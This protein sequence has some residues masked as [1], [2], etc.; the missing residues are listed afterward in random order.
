MNSFMY[1]CLYLCCWIYFGILD[2]VNFHMPNKCSTKCF[3]ECRFVLD[4]FGEFEDK[5]GVGVFFE[6]KDVWEKGMLA[7]ER[8]CK[9]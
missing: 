8:T 7:G 4:S 2:V 6:L 1:V 9:W 5:G 3:N